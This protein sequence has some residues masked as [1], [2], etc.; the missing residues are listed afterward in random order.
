MEG[1]GAQSSLD[2]G[3][4]AAWSLGWE[5]HLASKYFHSPNWA[6]LG[7]PRLLSRPSS[8]FGKQGTLSQRPA[9]APS[10]PNGLVS[11]GASDCLTLSPGQ[12]LKVPQWPLV[13]PVGSSA[14]WG[15]EAVLSTQC[16]G[17]DALARL[18]ALCVAA[19]PSAPGETG[20]L[21]SIC[22]SVSHSLGAFNPAS[23]ASF[24]SRKITLALP[25]V[26][27]FCGEI[28]YEKVLCK[29]LR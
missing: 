17:Q 22:S 6:V 20:G 5:A 9:K 24:M 7:R 8:S 1:R 29:H 18:F 13:I 25:T 11:E 10:S 19:L 12:E 3:G 23:Q 28:I 2:P 14:M 15:G 26:W 4:D 16:G 21:A 27:G